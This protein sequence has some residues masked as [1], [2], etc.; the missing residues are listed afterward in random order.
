MLKCSIKLDNSVKLSYIYL[1]KWIM[2]SVTAGIVGT[3]IVHCFIF[4]STSLASSFLLLNIP[5][6]IW[7]VAGA[8]IVGGIIYRIQP[9][10]AGEGIPSYIRGVRIHEGNLLFSITFYKYW[11]ALVTLT[12]LGNGGVVGPLGRVSSGAI[13]FIAGKFKILFNQQDQRTAAICGLAAAIGA[14]FHSSI[15]GGIFAVEIIQRK[16]MGYKDI[17][18]AIMSSSSAVFLCKSLGWNSFYRFD[19]ANEFMDISM[20][21]WLLLLS[22]ISGLLGGFYT[23]LYAKICKIIGRKQGNVLLKCVAGSLI[24]YLIAWSIN[25]ELLGTSNN[26]IGAVFSVDLPLLTGRLTSLDSLW[27]ILIIL[28]LCKL[29]C[30]CIT[31]GSGMSAGFTG[32]AIIAGMLLGAAMANFLHINSSSPTYHAFL[33]AGFSGMLAS[34]M[35]IPLAASVMAIEIFG[36]Q[37]SFPAGISAIIGFQLMRHRTIYDY[38]FDGYEKVPK[39]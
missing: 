18:P 13:A 30:N 16:N 11:A 19:A 27:L 3:L 2:L 37:C 38:A 22:L 6:L 32:R 25:P 36:L 5:L 26:I 35:N 34:S 15:G 33:A 31:V 39:K 8:I 21:G 28:L 12:T 14:I 10:A 20:V 24:A 9:H 1:I 4:L 7:P 29:I 17:F 23:S